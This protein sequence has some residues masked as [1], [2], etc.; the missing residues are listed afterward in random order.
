MDSEKWRYE[1]IK[2][3]QDTV[4]QKHLSEH[5]PRLKVKQGYQ[6]SLDKTSKELAEMLS[7]VSKLDDRALKVVEELPKI[8]A[9]MWMKMG[10]QRYRI[11]VDMLGMEFTSPSQRAGEAREKAID[12]MMW[13]ELWRFGNSQGQYLE[14]KEMLAKGEEDATVP[15]SMT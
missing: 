3:C 4:L 9:E 11:V 12:L 6:A 10:T 13:P 15:V 14:T 8:A 5:D 2:S 7:K 1:T